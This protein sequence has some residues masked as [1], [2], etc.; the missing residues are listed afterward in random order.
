MNRY[1]LH[2]LFLLAIESVGLMV[3]AENQGVMSSYG[4]KTDHV[5]NV[6]LSAT[7]QSKDTD[8]DKISFN[9]L[10]HPFSLYLMFLGIYGVIFN[11]RI[12]L[13]RRSFLLSK[14]ESLIVSVFCFTQYL[15]LRFSYHLFGR[16]VSWP[17][18]H[19][20]GI[21]FTALVAL[22]FIWFLSRSRFQGHE[23]ILPY[24][25]DLKQIETILEQSKESL[26]IRS[27]E[28]YA[29]F[30]QNIFRTKREELHYTIHR[31]KSDINIV[32]KEFNGE[33]KNI[34][35]IKNSHKSFLNQLINFLDNNAVNKEKS[36]KGV[37]WV[38]FLLSILSLI[39]IWPLYLA[40]G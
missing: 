34:S 2:G 15:P 23:V 29:S 22:C 28:K 10:L 12:L 32:I 39:L 7:Q 40:F 27:F 16:G 30:N 38:L 11:G 31:D 33:I 1:W 24:R 3:H 5:E 35:T 13:M 6:L 36:P 9:P 8:H 21:H 20:L 26:A 19:E 18:W 4:W 25:V 14:K 17:F 37:F